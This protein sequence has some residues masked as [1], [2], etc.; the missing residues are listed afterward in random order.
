MDARSATQQRDWPLGWQVQVVD[1][2]GSTNADLVRAA[3]N[4][5]ADRTVLAARHQTA[6]R[7]RLDR[8]W[9]ASPGS[10]LLVSLLFT[11]VPEVPHVL[12]QRVALAAAVACERVAGV[13]AA[14]KWPNDLLVDGAKLAGVLAESATVGGHQVVVVGIGINVR[15]SPEGAA[16]LGEGVDPLDVLAALLAAYDELPHDVG[17]MYRSQLATIGCRVRVEL[18]AGVLAVGALEGVAAD[19][20]ADGRLVVIDD[21]GVTHRVAVG[22]VVHLR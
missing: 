2:T 1:E 19:V 8:R 22:D 17:P 5:A 21:E 20:D 16:R 6:G 11:S 18:S 10:N 4:G 12:T 15:W 9:D 14:L 7:G 13:R 3:A